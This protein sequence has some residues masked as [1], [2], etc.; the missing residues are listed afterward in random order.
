MTRAALESKLRAN[1]R[2]AAQI[3]AALAGKDKLI[4]NSPANPAYRSDAERI[5]AARLEAL[6]RAGLIERWDYEPL[7]FD[8][9]WRCVY[10]PDFGVIRPGGAV[11]FHEVKGGH[12]WEDSRIKF[13]VAARL[14]PHWR[15]VWAKWASGRWRFEVYENG[16]KLTGKD[17]PKGLMY[18]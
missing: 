6:R 3:D 13:K 1:P 12:A 9:A 5:Y 2:Y 14:W 17:R 4:A 15:W 10:T 7:P 16:R 18:E 11:E 8:L